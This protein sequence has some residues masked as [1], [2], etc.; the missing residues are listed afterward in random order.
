MAVFGI[1][2][3]RLAARATRTPAAYFTIILS[4]DSNPT[5]QILSQLL[6]RT[7]DFFPLKTTLCTSLVCDL[8]H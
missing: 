3:R 7:V 8:E 6:S 2:A 1:V 5:L 4:V